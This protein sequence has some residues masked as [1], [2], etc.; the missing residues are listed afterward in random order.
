MGRQVYGTVCPPRTAS[1]LRES[2]A[3][4]L[5]GIMQAFNNSKYHIDILEEAWGSVKY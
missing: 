4:N 2:N 1:T 5:H 3:E